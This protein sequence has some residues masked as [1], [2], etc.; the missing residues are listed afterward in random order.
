M[1]TQ[2]KFPCMPDWGEIENKAKLIQ[3][4][5]ELMLIQNDSDFD[6]I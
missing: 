4:D 1:P 2:L 5:L 6:Q 3:L